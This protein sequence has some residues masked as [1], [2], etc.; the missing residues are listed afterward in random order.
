[1]LR[2]FACVQANYAVD[3]LQRAFAN[4]PGLPA[5]QAAIARARQAMAQAQLE[6]TGGSNSAAL[7]GN[8]C[9]KL[10]SAEFMALCALSLVKKLPPGDMFIAVINAI[11][12]NES[13]DIRD[14]RDRTALSLVIGLERGGWRTPVT[15]SYRE[16]VLEGLTN[17]DRMYCRVSSEEF[18]VGCRLTVDNRY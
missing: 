2:Q 16:F 10:A 7:V 15:A 12:S 6:L 1:V 3:T 18:R 5:I 4:P 17:S 9:D 14:E 11:V 13:I 8:M